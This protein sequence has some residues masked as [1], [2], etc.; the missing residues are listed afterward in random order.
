[1]H[2][3]WGDLQNHLRTQNHLRAP[4]QWIRS[5]RPAKAMRERTPKPT[6][7]PTGAPRG[8]EGAPGAVSFAALSPRFGRP[9]DGNLMY[10]PESVSRS[11]VRLRN[12]QILFSIIPCYVD[13]LKIRFSLGFPALPGFPGRLRAEFLPFCETTRYH[14]ICMVMHACVR[15]YVGT[16]IRHT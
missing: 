2:K 5:A 11:G 7:R 3:N 14:F 1:M 12:Y 6:G 4:A 9:C 15:T 8:P 13:V 16:C 10:Y